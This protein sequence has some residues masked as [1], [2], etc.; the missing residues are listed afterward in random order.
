MSET[1]ETEQKDEDLLLAAFFEEAR[2]SFGQRYAETGMPSTLVAQYTLEKQVKSR[3]VDVREGLATL[4]DKVA[5]DKYLLKIEKDYQKREDQKIHARM[6]HLEHNTDWKAAAV[7]SVGAGLVT[8]LVFAL[9]SPF[10]TAWLQPTA[11]ELFKRKPPQQ[12]LVQPAPT[13]QNI[14]IINNYGD[15]FCVEKQGDTYQVT[16]KKGV[17]KQKATHSQRYT[18]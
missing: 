2:E 8:G 16:P 12:S 1:D 13:N 15:T 5:F 14:Q 17:R 3:L 18:K 7:V 6:A 9:A 4:R 10:I 11:D